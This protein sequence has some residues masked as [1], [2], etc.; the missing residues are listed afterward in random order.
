MTPSQKKKILTHIQTLEKDLETLR[1]VRMEVA[2]SGFASATLSS[3]GGSRSYTRSS[4]SELTRVIAQVS[5][6]LDQYNKMLY[7]GGLTSCPYK[8]ILH[9]YS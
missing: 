5:Y 7:N 8:T 2:T 1:Q 3:G 6:E 9:V 4:M